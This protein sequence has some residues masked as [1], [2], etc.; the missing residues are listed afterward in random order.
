VRVI[1]Q[2]FLNYITLRPELKK[3]L[4]RYTLKLHTQEQ[5]LCPY[6]SICEETFLQ[7]IRDCMQ[8]TNLWSYFSVSSQ[9][10]HAKTNPYIWLNLGA[11]VTNVNIFSINI[12]WV[13]RHCNT[14]CI[15]NINISLWL[16]SFPLKLIINI[17]LLLF[18]III[19]GGRTH[20]FVWV[21]TNVCILMIFILIHL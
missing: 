4:I 16:I 13:R 12:W 17:K 3:S 20:C 10:S 8:S 18:Q 19:T 7:S 21:S 5:N 6:C 14:T 11:I 9:Y 15:F 2:L 1:H